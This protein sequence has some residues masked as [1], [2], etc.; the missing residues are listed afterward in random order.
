MH[1]GSGRTNDQAEWAESKSN[2]AQK[3][4]TRKQKKQNTGNNNRHLEYGPSQT[5]S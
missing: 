1:G 3:Q 5:S 4:T 2:Q